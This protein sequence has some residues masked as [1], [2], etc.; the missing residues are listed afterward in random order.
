MKHR[1]ITEKRDGLHWV[2]GT[3][4]VSEFGEPGNPLE[5]PKPPR[6]LFDEKHRPLY[7]LEQDGTLT[8]RG[9]PQEDIDADAQEITSREAR[10]YLEKT[11]LYVIRK[12]ETGA[13]IPEEIAQ[14]RLQAWGRMGE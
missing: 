7:T 5:I 9:R 2:V 4:L 1:Y 6:E 11:N 10:A 3:R 12:W 14:K 8:Y 13:E